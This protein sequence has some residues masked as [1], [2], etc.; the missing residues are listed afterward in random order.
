VFSISPNIPTPP[1]STI[2]SSLFAIS[3]GPSELEDARV[4]VRNDLAE[5]AGA[6]IVADPVEL[7]VI[8]CVEAFHPQFKAASATV[9]AQ[10][11]GD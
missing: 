11:E 8:P 2:V 10:R 9:F 4:K 5:V 3:Y 7:R 1:A 6:E